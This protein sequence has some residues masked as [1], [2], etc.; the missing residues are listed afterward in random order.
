M[1]KTELK[2]RKRIRPISDKQREKNAEWRLAFLQKLGKIIDIYGYSYCQYCGKKGMLYQGR[3]EDLS[4][5]DGHHIDG[6]RNNNTVENCGILHRKC[7]SL[8]TD[9]KIKW[10]DRK[11]KIGGENE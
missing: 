1:K 8:L 11:I 7:H 2:R 4:G 6:N 3:H 10:S 5:L 9:R